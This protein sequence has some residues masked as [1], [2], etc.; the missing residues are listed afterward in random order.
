MTD[1]MLEAVAAARSMLAGQLGLVEGCHLI[2][3][4]AWAMGAQDQSVFLPFT[5]V[6]SETDHLPIGSERVHWAESSLAKKD[7]ELHAYEARWKEHVH[8]ACEALI[9][10]AG[11]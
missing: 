8:L 1:D 2:T 4:L 11:T 10:Y 9:E 5:V 7:A 6:E 3:S